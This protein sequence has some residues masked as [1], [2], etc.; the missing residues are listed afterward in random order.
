MLTTPPT[1]ALIAHWQSVFKTYRHRLVPN[2]KVP[3]ARQH[4][5]PSIL[6]GFGVFFIFHLV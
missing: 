4:P 6:R 2:K 5:C 1:L 3:T